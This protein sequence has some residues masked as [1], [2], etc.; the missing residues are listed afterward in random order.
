MECTHKIEA[1]VDE[2]WRFLKGKTIFVAVSGGVD[3]MVLLSVFHQLDFKVEAIHLNYQLRGEDSNLD[4]DFVEHFCREKNIPFHRKTVRYSKGNVQNWARNERYDWFQTILEADESNVVALGHHADDQVETFFLNLFRGG[5]M[6]GLSGMLFNHNRIIRP[7]L[8]FSKAEILHFAQR[9]KIEWRED[10]SNQSL[11]YA[12]NKLRNEILPKLITEFP[13]LNQS[14]LTLVEVFQRNQKELSD[15]INPIVRAL[16][17]GD[18]IALNVV[19]NW[20]SFEWG[21]LLRQLELPL[22]QLE[23]IQKIIHL[24]RGKK[25]EI[26]H[27]DYSAIVRE[28]NGFSLRKKQLLSPQLMTYEVKKMPSVFSKNEIYL[29][30]HKVK[31]SLQLRFWQENDRI[32]PVG[33]KG[34]QLVSDVL[35]Q[36]KIVDVQ[37]QNCQ[38][39][40]DD[41]Q[42]HWVVGLKIG[43]K[44]IASPQAKEIL[45]CVVCFD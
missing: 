11:K 9:K 26:Q 35:R 15:K 25:I 30:K 2:N 39:L 28:E 29:D 13:Q 3:S 43:R 16:K 19:E 36:S 42:I 1:K 5:G 10:A 32:A 45:K 12:R 24:Q 21:E 40:T 17:Q 20:S 18:S 41:E 23:E 37:K 7:L 27:L 14:V 38:V 44:A 22:S 4:S 34:T 33:M 31:G 8:S 6:M